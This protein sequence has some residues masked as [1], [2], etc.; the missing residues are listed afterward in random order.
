[1]NGLLK[2]ARDTVVP[3]I[4]SIGFVAFAGK[5]LLWVRFRA[6]EV[7]QDQVVAAVPQSEA[8]AVGASI[9]LIFGFFGALATLGA[10]LVDRGGRATPGMVRALLALA[11]AEGAVATVL[12]PGAS[13]GNRVLAA[14]LVV[15]VGCAAFAMT[16]KRGK[17]GFVRFEDTNRSR[18]GEELRPG[19]GGDVRLGPDGRPQVSGRCLLAIGAP[20]IVAVAIAVALLVFD[21]STVIVLVGIV[22]ILALMAAVWVSAGNARVADGVREALLPEPDDPPEGVASVPVQEIAYGESCPI[23]PRPGKRARNRRVDIFVLDEGVTV[24]PAKGCRRGRLKSTR[25]HL[26]SPKEDEDPNGDEPGNGASD[27]A[28]P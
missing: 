28:S 21:I 11:A 9:L 3:V 7:P 8:V 1:M 2:A 4:V 24:K 19:S 13:P 14:V 17:R 20:A 18:K 16:F 5:V 6:L 27:S 22:V 26:P 15:V 25:W 23:D 10:Y 12:V